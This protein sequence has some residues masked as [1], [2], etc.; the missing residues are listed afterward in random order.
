MTRYKGFWLDVSQVASL[1]L[2]YNQSSTC[3]LKA[4]SVE[5]AKRWIRW[6]MRRV[7]WIN[8]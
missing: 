5:D 3:V 4:S 8:K 6:H 7:R 2:V 1:T